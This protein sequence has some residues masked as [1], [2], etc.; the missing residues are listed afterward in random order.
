M[1]QGQIKLLK[2]NNKSKSKKVADQDDD[3]W[4]CKMCGCPAKHTPLKRTGRD[5]KKSICNA[6]YIR[7]R[8]Q[9]ERAERGSARPILSTTVPMTTN[10]LSN[11]QNYLLPYLQYSNMIQQM[12]FLS[13]MGQGLGGM[14]NQ[15]LYNNPFGLT[16]DAVSAMLQAYQAAAAT[17]TASGQLPVDFNSNLN[18]LG[19]LSSLGLA[20]T[21]TQ[22]ANTANVESVLSGQ[23]IEQSVQDIQQTDISQEL[24]TD[25]EGSKQE[26]ESVQEQLQQITSASIS[27]ITNLA[28]A[29]VNADIIEKLNKTSSV[30]TESLYDENTVSAAVAALDQATQLNL[31]NEELIKE[32]INNLQNNQINDVENKDPKEVEDKKSYSKRKHM[33]E[34]ENLLEEKLKKE[35][36]KVKVD[37]KTIN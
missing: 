30:L 23:D 9:Q 1:M 11:Q 16:Q 2:M 8:T 34:E 6:C 36:K 19:A 21:T 14:D 10:M 31:K 24:K 29:D 20:A 33:D 3:D 32:K 37:S 18:M 12:N 26:L 35:L 27:E 17:A 13:K 28:A 22:A 15:Q 7:E 4:K 5:G 25:D